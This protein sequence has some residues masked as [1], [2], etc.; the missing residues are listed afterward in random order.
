MQFRT[1]G[2]ATL[3][4]LVATVLAVTACGTGTDSDPGPGGADGGADVAITQ[5]A[6]AAVALEHASSDTTRREA[7]YT[8]RD[9]APGA[10]GADLRYD[11]DGESDGDLLRV[12]L[13][14]ATEPTRD[15]CA[16][17]DLLDGCEVRDVAG[18]RLVLYWQEEEPEEDPG[19]VVVVM[20][21]KDETVLVG[22]F[23]DPITGDPRAQ[24]LTI[25]VDVLEEIAQDG[26]ISLTTTQDVVDLGEALDDW[27]G[28]E[29]DP[30]AYD[31]VPSTDAGIANSYVM[32]HGGYL[33]YTHRR[34]SPLKDAFG[35]GA[36]GGRFDRADE[37]TESPGAVIDVLAGPQAPPWLEG[38]PCATPRFA[39]H[40]EEYP[41]Q[42]FFLW[43]PGSDGE[44]WMIGLR[45]DETVAVRMAGYAVAEDL[46]TALVQADWYFVG[47]FLSSETLGLTTER[48]VL[49]FDF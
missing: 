49:E 10:L 46:E 43:E 37:G 31:R 48:H 11:G 40:C 25:P 4:T 29:P 47:E 32:A 26:R 15:P 42:R 20:L 30:T 12:F 36:I 13:S 27:E 23:G 41:R 1:R 14:P 33:A 6:I 39:G 17:G 9:D 18:G 21:R 24:D 19:E 3:L 35:P 28:G 7:S 44:A 2:A 16:E 22:W 45:D 8:D 5:R 34:P 38:D